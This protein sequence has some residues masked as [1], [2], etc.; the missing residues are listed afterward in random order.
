[1][2]RTCKFMWVVYLEYYLTTRCVRF[3]DVWMYV[4]YQFSNQ[5]TPSCNNITHI[6]SD[7]MIKPDGV[8]RGLIGEIIKR[9]E[10]KGYKLIAMKLTAPGKAHMGE[11]SCF[12]LIYYSLYI[13]LSFSTFLSPGKKCIETHYEYLSS[14]KFFP[15]LIEYMTSGPVCEYII[16]LMCSYLLFDEGSCILL[17]NVLTAKFHMPMSYISNTYFI[18]R[19]HGMGGSKRSQGRA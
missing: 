19:R 9:F 15:G 4:S 17:C 3:L 10:Q 7:I 5:H 6:I 2:E 8:Q 12:V 13:W 16:T 11:K 14:K 1:M 18:Y